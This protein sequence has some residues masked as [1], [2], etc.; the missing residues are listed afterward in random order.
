M[1]WLSVWLN[2]VQALICQ[3]G[4]SMLAG[5]LKSYPVY[6]NLL[7]F[8]HRYDVRF[9]GLLVQLGNHYTIRAVYTYINQIYDL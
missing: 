9:A 7:S 2:N 3:K 5:Y 6:R 1:I 8:L 4:I